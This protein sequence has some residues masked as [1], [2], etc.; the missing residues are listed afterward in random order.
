[1][2]MEKKSDKESVNSK[3]MESIDLSEGRKQILA[4]IDAGF[5]YSTE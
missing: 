5:G 1:M 3:N 2:K 4:N